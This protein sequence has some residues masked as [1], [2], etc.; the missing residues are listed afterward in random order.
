MVKP[1]DAADVHAHA[2]DGSPPFPGTSTGQR[3]EETVEH[4][5]TTL[6]RSPR[7]GWAPLAV[8]LTVVVASAAGVA[9][10]AAQSISSA[11]AN[12]SGSTGNSGDNSGSIRSSVDIQINDGTTLKTRYAWNISADVTVGSS[13]DS[14]GTAKHNVSFNVTAPGTYRLDIAQQRV[15]IVQRNSDAS[16]CDGS[17][18]ISGVTGSF[19][20]GSLTSGTLNLSDPGGV[21][22]GGGDSSVPFNQSGN[23]AITGT[24]NGSAQSHTLA[25]TWTGTSRSNSCEA[26]VRVGEGSSVSGCDAC[27]YPGTPSRTQS[28]DGHFVTV[29][30]VS[31]CGNGTLDAGEACDPG[32]ANS[33]CCGANCQFLSSTS[34]C[35]PSAGV[36]DN[37]EN[38]T[39]SSAACPA[40]GFKSTTTVCRPVAGVCDVAENCNGS[41]ANC[42]PDAML[43]SSTVCRPAAGVCDVAENCTGTIPVCPLDQFANNSTVCRP[44]AGVCD[45]AENCTGSSTACPADGFKSSA[46][47]CRPSAGQC[48]LAENCTGGTAT[49]PGDAKSTALCRAAVDVCDAAEFCDGVNDDC[50][51][52]LPASIGT[53]CRAAAGVCD[54]AETCDGVSTA[55][56]ADAKSTATCRP[57]AGDCDVAESCDGV[58]N[59][60][61]ADAFLPST[62][63]CRGV[64]GVCDVA[65]NCTGSSATCPADAFKPST[66]VCRPDAGQCDVEETCTGSGP[67]CPADAF[68]PD[69]TSCDDQ[70]ACTLSDMCVAGTC[71]GDSQ[72]CG[73]GIV[74]ANCGEE[75]DDSNLTPGDG[76]SPSCLAE[77]G[78]GCPASPIMGCRLPFVSGKAS[79]QM[80][81]KPPDKDLMKWKW[82]AGDR[83]TFAEW[84]DPVN[85]T[86]YQL[87][88]YDQTGL[89]FSIHVPAGGT[90]TGKPCWQ[91]K[92][93]KGYGY[94]DKDHTPDGAEK[95]LLK[96]GALGKA[97][98][99]FTGRGVNL[100]MPDLSTLAQP[101]R[102]QIENTNGLCWEA[103]YGPPPATQSPIIFK[104][105]AD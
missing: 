4:S 6:D 58:G 70:N 71:S 48:D 75:C 66:T 103:A 73:D 34:V 40:N 2:R 52:D 97:K 100:A 26:A 64:A 95:L 42:P 13:Q 43:P 31:L 47:V 41:S 55:C 93:I 56:P 88:I 15:G 22:N 83:T 54:I 35:R 80:F 105:K 10:A 84:G 82:L 29:T 74:E 19:T 92:G 63:E 89:R 9:P 11:S 1:S 44:A 24:S 104:D 27:V 60:C 65:E 76:C 68:E 45:V 12:T 77:P 37:A 94:K 8:V 85:T 38:C 51:F 18:D 90:C 17:A 102:V 69:G 3:N 14:N 87:C 20:G 25:F 78:L 59:D 23:A 39:G 101:I 16:N 67:D 57:S 7:Y 81:K 79:L 61:P 30:L 32:I 53:P 36:C 91:Q 86:N 46:T 28:S 33:P 62:T 5:K 98:I 49:C 99:L 21:G 96:E 72:L 50:P